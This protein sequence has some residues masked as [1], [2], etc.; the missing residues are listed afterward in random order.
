[1][2]RLEQDLQI[3]VVKALRVVLR[4][5]VFWFHV[6]NGGQR[7][8]VEGGILKAMGV[9]AGVPDLL[10]TW[11]ADGQTKCLAIELKVGTGKQTQSQREAM[12]ALAACGWSVHE[13]RSLTD[14]LVLLQMCNVPM[15]SL[16]L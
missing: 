6:P 8:A 3:G 2:K 7:S 16:R 11:L 12:Q 1:M 14:V 13:A 9:R 10:F 4:P 5:E 15:R